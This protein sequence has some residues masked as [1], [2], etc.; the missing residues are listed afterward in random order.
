MIK[1]KSL[2]HLETNWTESIMQSKREKANTIHF[3]LFEAPGGN[4]QLTF[5]WTSDGQSETRLQ[6]VLL[7]GQTA[8]S[9]G[10]SLAS[11]SGNIH[12]CC[13]SLTCFLKMM[14]IRARQ[15]WGGEH[16]CTHL[17]GPHCFNIRK[18]RNDV[19]S[20]SFHNSSSDQAFYSNK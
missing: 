16:S 14:I 4:F 13:D 6:D 17:P 10:A 19:Y 5:K 20:L 1:L 2:P 9:S 7:P 18:S 12:R 15:L 8:F 11:D 3:E